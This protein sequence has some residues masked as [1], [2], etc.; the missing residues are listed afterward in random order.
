MASHHAA[1]TTAT[2]SAAGP[3]SHGGPHN[4]SGAGAGGGASESGLPP[5]P[6]PPKLVD[7]RWAD[8]GSEIGTHAAVCAWGA[9]KVAAA[10]AR[11]EEGAAA[12]AK[13]DKGGGRGQGR[14]FE[15]QFRRAF[16]A[17]TWQA[18]L[19]RCG[20]ALLAMAVA[21]EEA[22][23]HDKCRAMPCWR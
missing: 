16:G 7:H 22:L 19:E 21:G 18:K 13:G 23:W 3:S 1:S 8:G 14:G 15:A 11:H 12:A 10:W 4:G 20:E 2:A 17:G 9:A 5:P 6:P